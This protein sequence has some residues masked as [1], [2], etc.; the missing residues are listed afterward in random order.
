[1]NITILCS[2]SSH[3]VNGMLDRWVAKNQAK[4]TVNLVRQ[5][6]ELRGGDI[7]FLISCG[8]KIAAEDRQA[9]R[10]VLVIHASDLPT[11]RG[12][13]PHI[14]SILNGAENITVSLLEAEDKVDSGAIW[15]KVLVPIAKH[16]LFDEINEVLFEAESQLMDFAVSMFGSIVPQ[17]QDSS[18]APSYY[19]RRGPEDSELDVQKSIGEQ[20]DLLRVCDPQRFP[21]FFKLHGH[22]YRVTVE[23]VE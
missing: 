7:L 3:P 4:H 21:A 14:W 10:K 16:A 1:M 11:G 23:K 22:T 6:A 20:F 17:P 2:S 18:R 15:K 9:F 19:P 13:S 5:K 12:W 8:E